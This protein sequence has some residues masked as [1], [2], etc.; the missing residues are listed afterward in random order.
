MFVANRKVTIVVSE[1]AARW[2]RIEAANRDTSVSKFVGA[3]LEAR[4]R[5]QQRGYEQAMRSYLSRGAELLKQG[6]RKGSDSWRDDL[7]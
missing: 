5:D 2:A 7:H 1:E 6:R 3:L 4:V